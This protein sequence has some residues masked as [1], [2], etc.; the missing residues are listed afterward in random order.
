MEKFS[1]LNP[2]VPQVARFPPLPNVATTPQPRRCHPAGGDAEDFAR[3]D[4]ALLRGMS[5][6]DWNQLD[7]G[8]KSGWT[9]FWSPWC[10]RR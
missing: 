8:V 9:A 7:K 4:N 6:A 10:A 1:P 2:R 3:P 5:N